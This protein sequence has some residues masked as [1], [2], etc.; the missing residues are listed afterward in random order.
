MRLFP[1]LLACLCVGIFAYLTPA[2]EPKIIEPTPEPERLIRLAQ[3]EGLGHDSK[4]Y[5]S[6]KGSF[7]FVRVD[8]E[9]PL[10]GRG[11]I[12]ICTQPFGLG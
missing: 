8:R 2:E 10:Q 5:S 12:R 3:P 11:Q 6:L 7:T 1:S 9:R 4:R